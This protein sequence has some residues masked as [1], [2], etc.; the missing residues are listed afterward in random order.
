MSQTISK[1]DLTKVKN[2]EYYLRTKQVMKN[3]EVYKNIQVGEVYYIKHKDYN[4]KEEYVSAGWNADPSKYIVFHK[5]GGFVFIKRIIA[6]GKP[7]QEVYC[8]TTQ[9]NVDEYWLEADP[10]Y[11]NSILLQDEGS[12]DPFAA[13]KLEANKKNKARRKNKKLEITFDNSQEAY[14]FVCSLKPG[15]VFYDSYTTYGSSIVAWEVTNVNRRK[16]RPKDSGFSVEDAYHVRFG[17]KDVVE[18]SIKVKDKNL[19]RKRQYMTT[20]DTLTFKSFLKEGYNRFYKVKPYTVDD[21]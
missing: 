9:F 16:A 6:S 8:L 11:V 13:S 15:D 21:V 19:P 14:D 3:A 20:H 1:E 10:D 5:D 2:C 18:I 7:G 17:F 12:Y 4:G